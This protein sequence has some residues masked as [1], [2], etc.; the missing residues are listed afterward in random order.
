MVGVRWESKVR[1]RRSIG[2]GVGG[3]GLWEGWEE[4]EEKKGDTV[5]DR[6]VHCW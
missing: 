6:W 2:R 5:S 3:R 1:R 4:K